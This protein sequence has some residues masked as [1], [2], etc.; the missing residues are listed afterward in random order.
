MRQLTRTHDD[1]D[2]LELV[3]IGSTVAQSVLQEVVDPMPLARDE[4]SERVLAVLGSSDPEQP[5][6]LVH[7]GDEEPARGLVGRA[8]ASS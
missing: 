5:R 3:G 4:M 1:H 7:V 8:A 2:P 6:M